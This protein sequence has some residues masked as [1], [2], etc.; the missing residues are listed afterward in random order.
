MLCIEN[1]I[2]QRI[3]E[4]ILAARNVP[5]IDALEIAQQL[6]RSAVQRL[7][8][9]VLHAVF[10]E[11]LFDHQL[12]IEP[13]RQLSHTEAHRGLE[14][15][16]EPV[17]L[18]NIVGCV[19][20]IA[21]RLL[22]H[23]TAIVEKHRR[24]GSGAGVTASASIGKKGD[25]TG[26]LSVHSASISRIVT[27]FRLE[28]QEHAPVRSKSADIMGGRTLDRTLLL[29][30]G[31]HKTGTTALQEMLIHNRDGFAANGIAIPETGRVYHTP[32]IYSPGHH[33]LAWDIGSA[34]PAGLVANL[35][36]ELHAGDARTAVISSEEFHPLHHRSEAFPALRA[37]LEEAGFRTIVVLYLRAQ[38][39][40]AESLFQQHLRDH[41]NPS[42]AEHIA[43][44]LDRG[45]MAIKDLH[46]EF[47]YSTLL[48]SLACSFGP[49]NIVVRPYLPDR[50]PDHIHHDFLRIIA[51]V[52]GPFS[53]PLTAAIANERFTLRALLQ[54][55]Y[56][57]LH[58]G[59]FLADEQLETFVCTLQPQFAPHLLDHRFLLL[60]YAESVQFLQ[61]FAAD[62]SLVQARAGAR[63]PFQSLAD[64]PPAEHSIWLESSMHRRLFQRLREAWS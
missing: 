40:Y 52:H 7:K 48:D 15:G 16:E 8:R 61:R 37:A 20:E 41:R 32:E 1:A 49:E 57:N 19:A 23:D 62:N 34:N 54:A 58:D 36:D 24:T 26:N 17:P 27:D 59:S 3:G 5:D 12:G 60:S 4:F 55:L 33:G 46:F 11:Q 31:T 56:R 28:F 51:A 10:P 13:Y 6:Q 22:D 45:R 21:K 38:A 18:G 43:E 39:R 30:V 9:R 53:F 2:D 47:F 64:I 25:V 44:I 35:I 63:I 50:G 29:H 42:F 14:P